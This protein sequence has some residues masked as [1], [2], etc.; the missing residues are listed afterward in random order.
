[1][2]M[3]LL[4]AITALAAFAGIVYC[5]FSLWVA[6]RFLRSGRRVSSNNFTP[7]VS[8]LK[9][10]CGVDPHAYDSLRSHCIQDYP[11]FE[12]IFGVADPQDPVVPAV[13]RLIDEFPATSIKLVVCPRLS[14]SNFKVSNLL[15][16]LPSARHE[17]LVINDSDI[18]VPSD[19]LRRVVAP[20]ETASVGIVTCLYRGIAGK[21]VGSRLESLGISSDFIPGVLC[22]RQLENRL[23]FAMGSTLAFRRRTLEIIGGLE[24]VADYLADDY[25]LGRRITEAGFQ[26]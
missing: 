4:Q 12:I 22:A 8:V 16:M 18:A 2:A 19:Y 20:L 26:V 17:H 21:T 6:I 15:Q 11:D 25:E 5:C 23:H 10:L 9:P 13:E 24:A 7:P 1:M 14:G 3:I